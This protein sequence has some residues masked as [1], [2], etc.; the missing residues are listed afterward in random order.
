METKTALTESNAQRGY[1]FGESA[2]GESRSDHK[3]FFHVGRQLE[4][5]DQERLGYAKN[6][7][8]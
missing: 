4:T 3:E 5:T 1:V 7:W 6:V 8:R 2:K